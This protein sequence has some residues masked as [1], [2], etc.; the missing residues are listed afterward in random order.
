VFKARLF[1]FKIAL[2]VGI[3]SKVPK[4]KYRFVLSF[5]HQLCERMCIPG[6]SKAVQRQ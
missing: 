6:L 2:N 3:V 4:H 1:A 5:T